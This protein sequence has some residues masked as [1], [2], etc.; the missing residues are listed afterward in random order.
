MNLVHTLI[1]ALATLG[2]TTSVTAQQQLD[3]RPTIIRAEAF[4]G[5]PFG[6]G[7]ITFRLGRH[8]E[9]IRQTGAV[10]LSDDAGRVLYPAFSDGILSTV[11]GP[12]QSTGGAQTVWFLFR[13]DTPLSVKLNAGLPT[14][15]DISVNS[16][17]RQ[18]GR[19]VLQQ[20]WRQFNAQ[21]RARM[22]SGDYPPLVETYLTT[23]LARRLE[24]S[25]PL[26][27]RLSQR[28]RSQLQQTF[29]LLFD[30]ESIRAESLRQLMTEPPG[31]NLATLALP[32]ANAW[33]PTPLG[34]Q[35]VQA[36]TEPIARFVPE[37]CI[38]LRFGNWDNQLWLKRLL[39]DYGGDLGRMIQ[40]RGHQSSDTSKLLDQLV[41]ESGTLDEWF[42]G[43]LIADVAVIGTDLYIEDGPSNAVVLLA[44]NKT[45]E[46]NIRGRRDRFAQQN[47]QSGVEQR[48]VEI[49]G[50][51]VSLLSAPD[52][53]ILSYYA[54]HQDCHL[55]S[56]SRY[57]V[58][59]FFEAAEGKRSLAGNLDFIRAR[60]IMPLDRQDTVFVYLSRQF[61]HNLLSPRYQIELA[62]RNRSLANIQLFQLAQ[63]AAASEGFASDSV[64]QMILH[65]LLP[66]NF[67]QL[68]DGSHC[69][70]NGEQWVDTLRGR[71]GYFK[72]IADMPIESITPAESAWLEDRLSTFDRELQQV[73]PLVVAI[74]RFERGGDVERVIF[75][76]RISP[77]G[78]QSYG[79]LATLL[80]PPMEY[81]ITSGADDLISFQASLAGNGWLGNGEPFQLFAAVQGDLPPKTDLRPT[82]ILEV[83]QLLK[84]TPGYL[85]AWPKPGYLDRLPALGR[86][87]DE[88]GYTYSR[89]LDLW[90]L[91]H[92]QFSLV[93]FERDRLEQVRHQ[94]QIVPAE[95]PAQVRLRV[96]DLANSN[97]KT[98]ANVMYFQRGWKTSVANVRLLNAMIQQFRLP[99]PAALERAE[100]LLGVRLVCPLGGQFQLTP[101]PSGRAVWV[102][103][104]WPA[105]ANPV[106]PDEYVA[107]PL[108]WFR[109]LQL[110]VYQLQTQFI[111][112]GALDIQRQPSG[113]LPGLPT[114]NLFG[115]FS[116][117]EELPEA[118][119]QTGRPPLGELPPPPRE[120]TDK[121]P[122]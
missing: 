48:T 66:Q 118:L 71:R 47:R 72:P 18:L 31:S 112:H 93:S 14:T 16:R 33:P 80:G 77:F 29:D 44:K 39:E 56:S 6:V 24:L 64:Q 45:L 85:G 108:E 62:R 23:M 15:V 5:Q 81:Q 50:H 25:P 20:W 106:V 91:Q 55:V 114:F 8:D 100:Q 79:W 34:L 101:T 115:G 104:Q 1:V 111:V 4:S 22:A 102:S 86:V 87:P 32:P 30:V 21:A 92:G 89:I 69:D 37:E 49:A 17:R 2:S 94:L 57:I 46:S 26:L 13:G 36:T 63:M 105:F 119:P 38:Y 68:P 117:V 73:D 76:A 70:F 107:P 7:K 11:L 78:Q 82:N 109:G 90:R 116:N 97:L 53:H 113:G 52:N 43:N 28:Q 121:R 84:S 122:R 83:Y 60:H 74:K 59:R 65:G 19:I 54:V 35:A 103:D 96:G 58:K 110:D 95:R 98:W 61:F 51:Q 9:L 88:N 10:S 42:G 3:E 40:L 12:G 120:K 67:N 99:P 41:L 75:D 27:D